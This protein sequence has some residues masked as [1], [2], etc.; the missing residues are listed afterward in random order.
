MAAQPI[1]LVVIDNDGCLIRDE[2]SNYDLAFVQ[3][4][5]EY[6]ARRAAW[7]GRRQR[8]DLPPVPGYPR[9]P[10]EL[11]PEAR[12]AISKQR[13]ER[14]AHLG[15]F[16]GF[17][18]NHLGLLAEHPGDALPAAAN[19]AE[20]SPLSAAAEAELERRNVPWLR[21]SPRPAVA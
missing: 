7:L 18:S 4:M 21:R 14:A 8:G 5:R 16:A 6:A 20:V 15:H 9:L 12:S 1:S 3:R 17:V 19:Y 10:A 11:R 2:F 13:S